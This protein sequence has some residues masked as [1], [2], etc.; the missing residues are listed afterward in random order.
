MY[1]WANHAWV[2]TVATVLIGPWLL[3]LAT[4]HQRSSA[5]LLSVGPLH[6][7]AESYPSFVLTLAAIAQ[8][9]VLPLLGAAADRRVLRRTLL[10]G[11]TLLGA[12]VAVALGDI[13]R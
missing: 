12:V 5:V 6:L 7:R 8:I 13:G 10:V 9:L 3:A 11:S 2:T 4:Q 1:S